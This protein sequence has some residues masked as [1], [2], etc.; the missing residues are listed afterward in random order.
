MSENHIKVAVLDLYDNVPNQGMRCI[1]EIVEAHSGKTLDQTLSYHIYETR[2]KNE[3]PHKDAYDIYISTGGPGSPYDGEG[4]AWEVNYFDLI[5]DLWNH[6]QRNYE[7]KKYVFFICHS[8]QM[9]CRLFQLAEVTKRKSTSFGIFPVHKV[10]SGLEDAILGSLPEPYYAVDSRDWQ[11]IQPNHHAIN[12]LGAEIISIEKERPHIN[13]ERAI[14][15][16][17]LSDEFFGTQYHP[18]ADPIGMT[19][20]FQ[21]EEKRKQIIENHGE[22]KYN[23]MIEHLN[24]PDKILMTYSTVIPNFLSNAIYALKG[25]EVIY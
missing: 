10:N 6:N 24:D 16:I 23:N 3:L 13:L 22:E 9:M 25:E 19:M 17:R 4:K 20:Y 7:K 18:E 21:Q 5:E 1:K 8:F 2:Y 12:D 14:M 11:V 15:A